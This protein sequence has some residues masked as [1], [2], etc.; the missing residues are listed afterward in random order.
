[1]KIDYVPVLK[2]NDFNETIKIIIKVQK[3]Y[4]RYSF[5]TLT[6]YSNTLRFRFDDGQS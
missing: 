6:V 2:K 3:K 1:M 5:S 4:L